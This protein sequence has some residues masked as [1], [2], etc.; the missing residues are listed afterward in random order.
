MW[1]E[2]KPTTPPAPHGVLRFLV[3]NRLSLKT[4]TRRA[5]LPSNV[6]GSLGPYGGIEGSG[7]KGLLTR[8]V[9]RLTLM[10][11]YAGTLAFEC[12]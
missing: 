3:P 4:A 1:S 12:R 6:R 7:A 5:R 10:A 8:G 11:M 2:R 9:N